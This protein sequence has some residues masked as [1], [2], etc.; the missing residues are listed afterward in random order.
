MRQKESHLKASQLKGLAVI[1]VSNAA[2]VGQVDDVYFDATYRRV[3]GMRVKK[4]MFGQAEAVPRSSV[5]AVGNDSLNVSSPEAINLEDR[6]A[7][8]AGAIRLSQIEGTK[9]VTE[10]GDLV[11]AITDML[12]DDE[13][14]EVASY[15]LKAPL[16]ERI[17][18]QEPQFSADQVVRVGE[19]GIMIVP[20]TVAERLHPPKA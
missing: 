12:L 19:G 16:W 17:R 4:G 9:V 15:L 14:T 13:A 6:F 10:G 1:T 18:H 8:L 5:T 20:N 2:K 7:D 11:G 3:L